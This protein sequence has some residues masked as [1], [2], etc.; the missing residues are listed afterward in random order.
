[1]VCEA[2]REEHEYA[3][4]WL[5][6][7]RF[8]RQPEEA[9]K[10]LGTV[11]KGAQRALLVS[12]AMLHGAPAGAVHRGTE[13]LLGASRPDPEVRDLLARRP[14]SERLDRISARIDGSGRVRFTEPDHDQALR[15]QVWQNFPDLRDHLSD[16]TEKAVSLPE[17]SDADR[18]RLVGRFAA[19]CLSTGHTGFLTGLV[20]RWT[21]A[22]QPALRRAAAQA[23]THGLGDRG[24]GGFFRRQIR[25]WSTRSQLP[26]LRRVL[27]EVCSDVLLLTHPEQALVRLHHL[28]RHESQQGMARYALARAVR[29]DHRLLRRLLFRFVQYGTSADP[30]LFLDVSAP[31]PLLDPG[32]RTRPLLREGETRAQVTACWATVFQYRP[33]SAWA[34]PV[35]AWFDAVRDD[36][37]YDGV[38]LGTLVAGC[39]HRGDRLALLY[40]AC[41]VWAASRPGTDLPDRLR[42]RI[43]T[44]QLLRSGS[45]GE[46][47][48]P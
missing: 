35:A 17:L 9:A 5:R 18:D 47:T 10:A 7:E 45:P 23:L 33:Q 12:S 24:Q 43:R 2:V 38:L 36:G 25:E 16:W 26:S 4:A 44:D 20:E 15:T 32:T 6:A 11:R 28:A 21:G 40:H 31:E 30:D 41:L 13:L 37:T 48:A 42:H 27:V 29:D 34:S 46:T 22:D 19:Q 39:R 14:L 8:L 1:V 3:E